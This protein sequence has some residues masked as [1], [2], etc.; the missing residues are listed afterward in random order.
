MIITDITNSTSTYTAECDNGDNNV[1][2]CHVDLLWPV[3]AMLIT[4][5]ATVNGY[6]IFVFLYNRL[7]RKIKNC[8][9]ANLALSDLLFVLHFG[10]LYTFSNIKIMYDSNLGICCS[11]TLAEDLLGGWI[12][13]AM[14]LFYA[15]S[16]NTCTI[17]SFHRFAR[18]VCPHRR[19]L[20]R[21]NLAVHFT[22]ILWI[23]SLVTLLPTCI[24]RDAFVITSSVITCM[25][26]LV[27]QSVERAYLFNSLYFI[28]FT[29]ILPLALMIGFYTRIYKTVKQ[30]KQ[31]TVTVLWDVL[32]NSTVERKSKR[33]VMVVLGVFILT[34]GPL[35]IIMLLSTTS[36]RLNWVV[37]DLFWI[38]Q[39]IRTLANFAIYSSCNFLFARC[40][41]IQKCQSCVVIK[42]WQNTSINKIEDVVTASPLSTLSAK[43]Y[44]STCSDCHRLP[45]RSIII[46]RGSQMQLQQSHQLGRL[47]CKQSSSS[48]CSIDAQSSRSSVPTIL[49]LPRTRRCHQSQSRHSQNSQ[50][51]VGMP[52]PALDSGRSSFGSQ[53]PVVPA[54]SP[55]SAALNVYGASKRLFSPVVA[56]EKHLAHKSTVCICATR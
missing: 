17:I 4:T 18:I 16:V 27:D 21:H 43:Q 50:H 49:R 42:R 24:R 33:M 39:L 5:S 55:G 35:S 20:L 48:H 41:S 32:N 3:V 10:L 23:F 22:C 1:T 47:S 7:W 45:C 14:V 25:S 26:S 12:A 38:I 36:F 44:L 30:R 40:M 51:T 9:V 52:T 11:C 34:C 15:V 2:S 53:F 31:S 37:I 29:F 8:L 19:M 54:P 56:S 13:Y 28:L 46:S 6:S